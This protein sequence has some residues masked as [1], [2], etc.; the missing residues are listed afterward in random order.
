MSLSTMSPRVEPKG[1]TYVNAG[2]KKINN[3]GQDRLCH[4]HG[5]QYIIVGSKNMNLSE[6][7]LNIQIVASTYSDWHTLPTTI[8]FWVPVFSQQRELN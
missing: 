6:G 1:D 8:L 3:N 2:K 7:A 5:L 4:S